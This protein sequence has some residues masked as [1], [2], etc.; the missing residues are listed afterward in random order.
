MNAHTV[1][2]KIGSKGIWSEKQTSTTKPTDSEM[3]VRGQSLYL[4]QDV[5]GYV[6][7]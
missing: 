7:N 3:R 2:I 5:I 6:D 1:E 4:G